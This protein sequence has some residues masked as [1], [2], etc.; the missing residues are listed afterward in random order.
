MFQVYP[1]PRCLTETT[2]ESANHVPKVD[3]TPRNSTTISLNPLAISSFV[4][5]KPTVPINNE[6]QK[7]YL[8]T[9]SNCQSP[10]FLVTPLDTSQSSN[11]KPSTDSNA[12][13][14]L[15]VYDSLS[16][17]KRLSEETDTNCSNR[18]STSKRTKLDFENVV[19]IFV[20]NCVD[21]K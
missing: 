13:K 10:I 12:S 21:Y 8:T 11:G 20:T 15:L 17:F 5:Y 3:F 14:D 7:L 19:S 16:G 6:R 9:P 18:C 2:P 1:M 4:T